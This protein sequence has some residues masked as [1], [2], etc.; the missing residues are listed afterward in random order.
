[1]VEEDLGG[2]P[3]DEEGVPHAARQLDGSVAGATVSILGIQG[4]GWAESAQS[5][6]GRRG[7]VLTGTTSPGGGTGA[8]PPRL[9]EL[10]IIVIGGP[11]GFEA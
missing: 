5:E 4:R 2:H 11:V 10:D 7:G 1:M 3:A 9:V 6:D 8:P